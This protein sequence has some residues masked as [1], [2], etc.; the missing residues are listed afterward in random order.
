MTRKSGEANTKRAGPTRR[1]HMTAQEHSV[2]ETNVI[3]TKQ[4]WSP[5]DA[6]LG[7]GPR[8]FD[9]DQRTEHLS[10]RDPEEPKQ[11]P[12]RFDE[13]NYS[14]ERLTLSEGGYNEYAD[15]TFAGMT[16]VESTDG[17]NI[18]TFKASSTHYPAS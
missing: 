12:L 17:E 9:P 7:F 18:L 6:S 3:S 11:G 1:S 16:N 5:D 4:A 10:Y 15:P 14:V 2:A 8:S 13:T